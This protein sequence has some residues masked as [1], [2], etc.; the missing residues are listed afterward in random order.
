MMGLSILK[1]CFRSSYGLMALL[2]KT[3]ISILCHIMELQKERIS[4]SLRCP[5]LYCLSWML[6]NICGK[7][8]RCVQ[9]NQQDASFLLHNHFPLQVLQDNSSFIIQPKVFS[10]V[11]FIHIW[12]SVDGKIS[13]QTK[14]YVFIGYT[15]D[16]KRCK[17]YCP[18]YWKTYVS[19]NVA[20][21]ESNAYFGSS[22]TETSREG[23]SSLAKDTAMEK[24]FIPMMNHE[25]ELPPT[26]RGEGESSSQNN[27]KGSQETQ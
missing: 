24:C 6:P 16:K 11:C 23:E 12:N 18:V 26:P 15:P 2:F 13:T 19:M 7:R 21:C 20:F 27:S 8:Q 25:M 4:I 17:Y 22:Q 5:I 9:L 10:C 1:L 3:H 14:K